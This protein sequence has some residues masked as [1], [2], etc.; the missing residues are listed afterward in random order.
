MY[1]CWFSDGMDMAAIGWKSELC[2][3]RATPLGRRLVGLLHSYDAAHRPTLKKHLLRHGN[4]CHGNGRR[5]E[6]GIAG[7]DPGKKFT[8]E[9]RVTS[10]KY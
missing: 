6:D 4:R 9:D 10:Y 2:V 1:M 8:R 5:Q 7:A 3:L